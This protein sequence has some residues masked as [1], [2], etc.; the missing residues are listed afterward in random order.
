MQNAW[1]MFNHIKHVQGWTIMAC[2]VYD[3]IYCKVM[4]IVVYDMQFKDTEV[5][6]IMWRKLNAIFEKKESGMPIFK[7]F[8]VDDAQSN[9]NV[10]RIVYGIGDPMV[11]MVDKE[12]M[13][14]FH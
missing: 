14:F 13:C 9:W 12:W 6:C 7:G 8:M 3:P 5:Q 4:M 1:M 2:H 11:K 10:V